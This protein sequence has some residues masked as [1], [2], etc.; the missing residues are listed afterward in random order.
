GL[1][2]REEREDDA[3]ERGVRLGEGRRGMRRL[4]VAAPRDVGD[5]GHEARAEE[6]E[7]LRRFA[8]RE[9]RAFRLRAV[10]ATER[11]GLREQLIAPAASRGIERAE[12]EIAHAHAALAEPAQRSFIEARSPVLVAELGAHALSE[13]GGNPIGGLADG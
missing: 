5:L 10:L 11:L 6:E 7:R 8:K 12:E 2:P 4:D 9:T 13:F 1:R 3:V